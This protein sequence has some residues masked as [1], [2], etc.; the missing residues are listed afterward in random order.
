MYGPRQFYISYTTDNSTFRRFSSGDVTFGTARPRISSRTDE[1]TIKSLRIRI[2][3]YNALKADGVFDIRLSDI[4]ISGF[5]LPPP[6]TEAP[7]RTPTTAPPTPPPTTLAPSTQPPT[8][9][10]T[11]EAPAAPT[12]APMAQVVPG[13]GNQSATSSGG[14][15]VP[16][17]GFLRGLLVLS[18]VVCF[19]NVFA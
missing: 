12:M 1:E 9:P 8:G 5:V 16:L 13:A 6:T 15:T 4:E 2:Y 17:P 11:T 14:R 10:P 19:V 3:G 7:T 18:F